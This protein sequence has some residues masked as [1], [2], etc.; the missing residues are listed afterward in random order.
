MLLGVKTVDE[1][2]LA[3]LRLPERDRL[4]VVERVIHELAEQ[5]MA[6][7]NASAPND[8]LL[9][10]EAQRAL[11]LEWAASS[12]QGPLEADDEEWS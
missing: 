6:R 12:R 3:L 7:S 11:L 9:P 2:Y 8:A 1:V 4:R 5:R 10:V